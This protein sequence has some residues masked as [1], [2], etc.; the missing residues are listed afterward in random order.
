MNNLRYRTL[1]IIIISL[2]RTSNLRISVFIIEPSLSLYFCKN[3]L[4]YRTLSTSHYLF[5]SYNMRI[6]NLRISVIYIELSL[7]LLL[8]ISS[9]HIVFY[10]L[11]Q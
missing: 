9:C 3:N 8:I 7:S 5:I 6:S 4:R 10:V 11:L 2:F 1:S